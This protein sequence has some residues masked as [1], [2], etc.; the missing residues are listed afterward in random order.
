M[1][2]LPVA[3]CIVEHEGTFPLI[4][5]KRNY[6][7]GFWGLP[8][9]K[10][11]EDEHAPEAAVRELREELGIE[12]EFISLVGVVDELA[13]DKDGSPVRCILFVCRMKIIGGT[14]G[15]RDLPEG[16]VEWFTPEQIAGMEPEIVPSD[17]RIFK[18]FPETK[19]Y[20]NYRSRQEWPDG[21]LSLT[22]F[23]PID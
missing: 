14:P 18:D 23:E 13:F 21:T 12:T 1:K 4:K 17:F 9:G 7:A 3:V 5:F 8:G 11:D 16:Q 6:L 22:Y 10:I 15:P 2:T 20:G 19:W